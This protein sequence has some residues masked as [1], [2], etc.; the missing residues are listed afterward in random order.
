MA[1]PNHAHESFSSTK[2]PL[3]LHS[4]FFHSFERPGK[5]ALLNA[6]GRCSSASQQT[7]IT[8]AFGLIFEKIG[9][10]AKWTEENLAQFVISS[11]LLWLYNN[12]YSISEQNR[13]NVPSEYQSPWNSLVKSSLNWA[14]PS[15]IPISLDR[16]WA[17]TMAALTTRFWRICIEASC[18]WPADLAS[19]KILLLVL[20]RT[21]NLS[22]DGLKYFQTRQI[23]QYNANVLR[24]TNR[25]RIV[26]S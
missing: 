19:L 24:R 11:L 22:I 7:K 16:V 3:Q 18:A 10:G 20:W 4:N 23:C 8:V 12:T 2:F 17:V 14:P 9:A 5:S 26:Q 13:R 21:I 6:S 25:V 1:A 15:R